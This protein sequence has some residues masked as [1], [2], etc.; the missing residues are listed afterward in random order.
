VNGNLGTRLSAARLDIYGPVV[1]FL[2][3][4]SYG[5][6]API[7]VGQLGGGTITAG[8]HRLKE[9][10]AGVSKPFPRLRSELTLVGDYQ[11]LSGTKRSTLTLN[12]IF[13]LGHRGAVQ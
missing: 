11:D 5:P 3:G 12:Y 9:G 13:H 10:Y 2:A 8:F 6:V 7:V 1:N 4:G